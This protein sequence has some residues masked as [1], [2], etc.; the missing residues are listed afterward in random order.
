[1]TEEINLKIKFEKE[2]LKNVK[3]VFFKKL[4]NIGI[5]ESVISLKLSDGVKNP[6]FLGFYK[7]Y[8]NL[9]NNP[10]I[11]LNIDL[12]KKELKKVY[13]D[14]NLNNEEG[15]NLL[16]EHLLITLSHEYGHV[17]EEFINKFY[18]KN[19]GLNLA[20]ELLKRNFKDNEDF[21]EDFAK[22]INSD[23]FL[24]EYK[25]EAIKKI[26]NV[27]K[28]ETFTEYE[29][30]EC[31][32]PQWKNEFKEILT[33]YKNTFEELKTGNGSFNKCKQISKFLVS[34]FSSNI[35]ATIIRLEEA[36]FNLFNG[37]QEWQ[38]M[39]PF[40]AVHYAVLI[41]NETIID[42]TFRQ[43]DKTSDFPYILNTTDY[44]KK[45]E[46]SQIVNNQ[47]KNLSFKLKK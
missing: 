22:Y 41:D 47:E 16:S 24:E 21:A 32:K 29:L 35:N 36:K 3:N 43:F 34:K 25:I 39:G 2:L 1:M 12:H 33:K 9:R 27:F 10:I 46:N 14:I 5:P 8:S 19:E 45:W 37:H 38:K 20:L 23:T 42:L 18:D 4:K 30:I 31:E 28:K 7:P 15:V 6:D 13:E 26:L 11:Y 17:V 40:F 44:L